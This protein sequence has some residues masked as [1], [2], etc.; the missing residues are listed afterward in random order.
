VSDRKPFHYHDK[1]SLA[2]IGKNKAVAQIGKWKI[3]GF[4]AWVLWGGVHI[5]FLIGF[6]NRIAVMASWIWNWL[7]NARDARLIT[8][9]AQIRI[10]QNRPEGRMVPKDHP[11]PT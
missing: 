7:I 6:R 5:M 8:G 2:T 1:G 10:D 3:G 4:I 11:E 9:D